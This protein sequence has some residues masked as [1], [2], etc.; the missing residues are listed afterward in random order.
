MIA[1]STTT[2]AN[3]RRAL[4]SSASNEWYTPRHIADTARAVLGGIDLDPASCAEANEVIQASAFYTRADDGLAQFWQGRIWLNPPYGRQQGRWAARLIAE[5]EAG[6]ISAAILLVKAATSERWFAPLWCYP[7]CFPTG[8]LSFR[9][10][11]GESHGNTHGSAL[12]YFGPDPRLFATVF[13]KLGAVVV[14]QRP[15]VTQAIQGVL[16]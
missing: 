14:D 6:R 5:Y 12:V 11:A 2:R 9:T 1:P 13:G 10:D 4:T 8:R 16:L 7:I 3:A 15:L